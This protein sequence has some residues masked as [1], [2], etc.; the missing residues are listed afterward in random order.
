MINAGD[1]MAIPNSLASS[2]REMAQPSLLEST[3]IGRPSN[4]GIKDPFAGAIKII[5][6][7]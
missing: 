6:I 4:R 2:L 5:A 1:A 3:I 7:H